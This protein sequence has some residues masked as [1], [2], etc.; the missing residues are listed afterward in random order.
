MHVRTHREPLFHISVVPSGVSLAV[1]PHWLALT[2][3]S[4][5][6]AALL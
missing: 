6:T 2:M 1:K 4:M 5:M 3:S